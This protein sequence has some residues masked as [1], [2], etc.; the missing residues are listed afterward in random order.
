MKEYSIIFHD[1]AEAARFVDYLENNELYGSLI[2]QG[3]ASDARSLPGIV[4]LDLIGRPV[5]FHLNGGSDSE[6]E[7]LLI[8]AVNTQQA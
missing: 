4:A 2:Y 7:T 3:F 5:R 1:I 8:P 6:D